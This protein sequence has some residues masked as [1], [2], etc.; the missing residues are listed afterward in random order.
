MCRGFVI[1]LLRS[2]IAYILR[3]ERPAPAGLAKDLVGDGRTGFV[4]TFAVRHGMEALVLGFNFV[5]S[6]LCAQFVSL[7]WS[8]EMLEGRFSSIFV[9]IYIDVDVLS[10]VFYGFLQN[11]PRV[12]PPARAEGKNIS[13]RSTLPQS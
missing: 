9:F 13:R 4:K 6:L 11:I 1:H 10:L 2:I 8:P 7:F 12:I 5:D 3:L